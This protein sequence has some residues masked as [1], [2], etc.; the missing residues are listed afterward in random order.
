M[1]TRTRIRLAA[2]ISREEIEARVLELVKEL[3]A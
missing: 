2:A 1:S 3:T